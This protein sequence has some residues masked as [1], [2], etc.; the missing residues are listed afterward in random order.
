MQQYAAIRPTTAHSYH[1]YQV[2]QYIKC[3]LLADIDDRIPLPP[4]KTVTLHATYLN[5]NGRTS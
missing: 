1:M 4:E 5:I 3:L 2:Q